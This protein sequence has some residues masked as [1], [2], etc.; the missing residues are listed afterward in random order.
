MNIPFIENLVLT[1]IT[2][3][4]SML[5]RNTPGSFGERVPRS[6]KRGCVAAPGFRKE[7]GGFFFRKL[8]LEIP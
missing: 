5:I 8:F 7:A 1:I 6:R 3:F 4:A 2:P